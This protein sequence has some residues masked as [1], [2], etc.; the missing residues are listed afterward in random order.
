MQTSDEKISLINLGGGAAIEL[1]DIELQKAL[2]DIVD[3]NTKA[4]AV[5]E[6]TLKVRIKP[7]E[8]RNFGDLVIQCSSKV[9]SLA[10]YPTKIVIGSRGRKGEAYELIPPQKSLFKKDDAGKVI[11]I[12]QGKES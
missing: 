5:R 9:A 3:P 7:D 12:E 11:P 10:P 2:D 8:E 4:G 1:F 6:V